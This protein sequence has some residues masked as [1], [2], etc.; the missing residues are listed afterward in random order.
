MKHFMYLYS[1]PYA[2]EDYYWNIAQ[3]PLH[4]ESFSW[5]E[6]I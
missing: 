3:V 5:E 1:Q 4:F 2:L 6:I